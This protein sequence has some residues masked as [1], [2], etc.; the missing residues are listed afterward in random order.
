M[1]RRMRIVSIGAAVAA[2]G[3][4][5][6]T[7]I[8]PQA[9]AANDT[10]E[11]AVTNGFRKAVTTAGI[12]EHLKALEAIAAGGNRVS[13]TPRYDAS[14]DYVKGSDASRRLP[15]DGPAVRVPLQRGHI[16]SGVAAHLAQSWGTFVDGVDFS[17]MTYS[18]NGDVTGIMW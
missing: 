15:G 16:S 4:L 5:L 8:A 2:S 9:T 13:G 1:Q 14:V 11:I 12:N 6:A 18:G 17:S 3:M 7:G 10:S